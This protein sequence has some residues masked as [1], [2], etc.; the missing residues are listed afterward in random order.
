MTKHPAQNDVAVLLI[1]FTR[2]ETL[3]RTFDVIRRSR[4]SRLYLYQDGPRNDD[5]ARKIEEAR[6]IVDDEEIDWECDVRRSY[7]EE[8]SGAWASNYR[9]QRW[10][11]TLYDKC[12]IIEDDS[13]PSL[14]F[15]PFCTEMLNRYEH[16]ERI[17]MIA[18]YNHE[19]KTDA[20]YDYLFTTVFSI[21]GWAT[22]RRV[23][24]Q[25]NDHYSVVDDAFDMHQLEVLCRKHGEREEMTK[26]LYKHKEAGQP[27]Y[28]SVCWSACVLSSG[29]VI[30]PTRNLIQN[31]AVS[32]ESAHFQNS[33]KTLPRRMQ[34]MLTMPSYELQWPLR[35]PHYVIEN[36]EYKERVHRIMAW[37]HPWI[38]IGRSFEELYRNLRYGN[39]RQIGEAIVHRFKKLTGKSTYS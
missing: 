19:E 18:G 30:T 7:H 10:A 34:Q 29:L 35:H 23:V 6:M 24:D 9:A 27:I 13:T 39:F 28:E 22:W 20:P 32:E 26:K 36:V 38:K 37:G 12:I 25:W 21:W 8:N 3:R 1:F 4:P 16:D 17:T 2:T 33:M 11:F 31:T 14:S 5:E 15:I